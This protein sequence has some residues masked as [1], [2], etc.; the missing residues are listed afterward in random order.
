[1][2]LVSSGIVWR[3]KNPASETVVAVQPLRTVST[4]RGQTAEVYLSDGTRVTL[5]AA[6]TL[7]FPAAFGAAR[8]VL[9]EGEGYFDVVH[10]SLRPF[11]V[12]TAHAVARDIGTKFNVRAYPGT[13]GTEVLVAE[14]AVALAAAS[15]PSPTP[16]VTER[17]V[18]TRADLGR[19]DPNGGLT[20]VRG[21]DVDAYLGWMHGRLVFADA[22]ITEVLPRL[23][24]WYDVELRLADSSLA[25]ARVT[26]T[27]EADASSEALALVAAALDARIERHGRTVVLH[28]KRPGR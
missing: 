17:L 14:G 24:E 3:A 25:D 27:L 21:V 10:D 5:G 28:R 20:V 22:P 18:L 13:A 16:P 1:V 8:D 2:L 4:K 15:H 12:H 11:A 26:A 6:S 7:R 19:L 9:L 23:G